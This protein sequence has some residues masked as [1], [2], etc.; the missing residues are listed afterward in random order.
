MTRRGWRPRTLRWR[1]YLIVGSLL[2]LLLV[3]AGATTAVRLHVTSVGHRLSG[4]LRPAQTAASVL[5]EAYIDEETGERGFLLT[6]DPA[7]L[8]PYYQGEST[9]SRSTAHL[10]DLFANDLR[11]MAMLTGVRDGAAAWRSQAIDP[12]LTAFE[13]GTLDGPQLVDSVGRGKELF[14]TLRSRL[15]LL[16]DRIDSL[17]S[18]ALQDSSAAQRVANNVTIAAAVAAVLLAGVAAWQLRTSFAM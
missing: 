9:A 5:A 18:A 4:T 10:L 7:F 17:V 14:D 3:T 2:V 15:T 8:R 16:E 13:R 1:V 11:T 12:E 6:R